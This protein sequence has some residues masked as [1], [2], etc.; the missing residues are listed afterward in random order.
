MY[1]WACCRE[2]DVG[3]M[4][5]NAVI[6]VLKP[7]LGQIYFLWFIYSFFLAASTNNTNKFTSKNGSTSHNKSE[8]QVDKPGQLKVGKVGQICQLDFNG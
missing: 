7:E 5:Y 2:S 6:L 1:V 8:N 3:K 4:I